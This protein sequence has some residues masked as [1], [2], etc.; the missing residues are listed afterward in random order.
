[1][2]I[3][4]YSLTGRVNILVIRGVAKVWLDGGWVVVFVKWFG[5]GCC[6]PVYW[7]IGCGSIVVERA[8]FS[9][10]NGAVRYVM[11]LRYLGG[12]NGG[13]FSICVSFHRVGSLGRF[14]RSGPGG[15]VF[16]GVNPAC[17]RLLSLGAGGELLAKY[18]CGLG[19]SLLGEFSFIRG[20]RSLFVGHS[21]GLGG[22]RCPKIS[23]RRVLRG[24]AILSPRR[25]FHGGVGN[26]FAVR[27]LRGCGLGLYIESI[28]RTG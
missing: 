7:R 28:K 6:F 23:A 13:I 24:R 10:D 22:V 11:C 2:L 25:L 26:R 5:W 12:I 1:M 4:G 16:G 20:A 8:R 18:C 21:C 27:R 17:V 14:M 9:V 3:F 15:R 19:V